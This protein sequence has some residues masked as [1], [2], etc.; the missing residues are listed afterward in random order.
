LKNEKQNAS[1]FLWGGNLKIIFHHLTAASKPQQAVNFET[2]NN[3]F[4]I[5]YLF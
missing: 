5:K 3:S 2:Q 4:K 1:I